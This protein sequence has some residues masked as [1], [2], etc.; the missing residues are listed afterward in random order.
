MSTT[1]SPYRTSEGPQD[2]APERAWRRAR[3]ALNLLFWAGL[4]SAVS[5]FVG[6]V[7]IRLVFEL[8]RRGLVGEFFGASIWPAREYAHSL[9]EVVVIAA[10]V[11]LA[12]NLQG[13]SAGRISVRVVLALSIW[14]WC[15]DVYWSV[16]G[17]D[18]Y[19]LQSVMK[20]V[21][22]AIAAALVVALRSLRRLSAHATPSHKPVSSWSNIELTAL[23]FVAV[24]RPLLWLCLWLLPDPAPP[25][26]RR[27]M[28]YVHIAVQAASDVLV[29]LVVNAA[30]KTIRV[31]TF[32]HR[33]QPVERSRSAAA[34][35]LDE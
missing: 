24:V 28:P 21:R 14:A 23:A 26:V 5:V 1:D 20:F 27:L 3:C 19:A 35:A 31:T 18:S 6:G 22:F 4:G 17:A 25:A 13:S 15:A 10:L 9:C 12:R 34:G 2:A 7:A 33:H 29:L 16:Y 30:R 11:A 8:F 32:T